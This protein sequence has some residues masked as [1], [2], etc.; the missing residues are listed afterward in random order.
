MR[1]NLI[2]TYLNN[3]PQ[4]DRKDRNLDI[5]Y[6]LSNR[7]F[8]K[9]LQSK[10]HLINR[11]LLAAPAGM[12]KNIAYDAKSFARS[13]SGKANDHEL[14]KVNDIG[15]YGICRLCIIFCGNVHL[16]QDCTSTAG[17]IDTRI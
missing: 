11:G 7:T 3:M 10:G 4:P 12:A 15:I 2:Q 14:G 8:I 5:E 1:P 6:V 16:A 17:K 9:P 13:V